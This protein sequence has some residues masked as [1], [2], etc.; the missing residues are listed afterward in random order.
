MRPLAGTRVLDLSRLLPGPFATLVLADLGATVDKIEDLGG[1]DYLRHMP[2]QVAGE[3]AA[4]QLLNR[5]KRSALLDL[6]HPEGRA[7][8]ERLL[9]SY[10]VLFEQFRP[11][12][13]ARLGLSH[14]RLLEKNPR[15]VICALT[16][17]GQTGPLAQ[18]A[19]HDL[20]YLARGGLL[21][22]QG[23]AGAPPQPPGFQLADVS[24]GMWSV[25]AILAALAERARTG[26][27]RVLD[28]SMAD[29]VLGFATANLAAALAGQAFPRGEDPLGGGIAP[30]NTY[31][32]SD[33]HPLALASLE[34]KFWMTFCAGVGIEPRMDA[35]MP[36]PHQ[37]ELRAELAA[38]FARKTR[39][40]WV[41]FSRQH[42]CCLEPVVAPAE[43]RADPHVAARGLVFDL[44]TPRGTIP[45]LRT[46]VTPRDTS[47]TAPPRAGEHTRAI[48]RDAGFSDSEIDALLRAGAIREAG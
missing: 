38:L 25:I 3:A 36:G 39:E 37:T 16:G 35:L 40:E 4:F 14:E 45:Q 19:G 29:G 28:I 1:G 27:G 31:L 23:P 21:G 10:D 44:E 7:A 6:K 13:L 24:G 33:G 8:F 26:Q 11:G 22:A 30:Y 47:F 32:S 15:L 43:L 9:A 34:P 20:N 18:R 17:Y 5:G 46:P 42:D 2:P 48:L 12:V 41:A